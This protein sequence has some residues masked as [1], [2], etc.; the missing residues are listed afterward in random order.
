MAE[1][2]RLLAEWIRPR[3]VRGTFGFG[4]AHVYNLIRDG[5]V[6]SV[7][8]R[9]PGRATG[10]RLVSV[11]SLRDYIESSSEKPASGANGR[12]RDYYSELGR[13]GAKAKALNAPGRK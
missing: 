3:D 2:L 7:C 10:M 1:A 5:K 8:V 11:Q 13:K 6:R 9:E 4:R 12:T